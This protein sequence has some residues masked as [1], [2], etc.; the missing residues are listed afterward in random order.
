MNLYNTLV[1]NIKKK[2]KNNASHVTKS[3]IS[4]FKEFLIFR[5]HKEE[6]YSASNHEVAASK[7][8]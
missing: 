7:G 1:S 3:K 4:K 6:K 5:T 2:K 8:I